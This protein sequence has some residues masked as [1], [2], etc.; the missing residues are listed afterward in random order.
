[1]LKR[2]SDQKRENFF[3][4]RTLKSRA[5]H[6]RTK[7]FGGGNSKKMQLGKPKMKVLFDAV[8]FEPIL[9]RKLDVFAQVEVFSWGGA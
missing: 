4:G 5:S 7:K 8:F 1:V 3:Q 2:I 9:K 6:A